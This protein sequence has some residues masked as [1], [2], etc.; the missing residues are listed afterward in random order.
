MADPGVKPE[1]E[2][3]AAASELGQIDVSPIEALARIKTDHEGVEAL[4]QRA[5]ERREGVPDAVYQRVLRDYQAR[6]QELDAQARPLRERARGE[7]RRLRDIHGRLR[8]ALD[9]AVLDRQEIEFRHDISEMTDEEFETR[10]LTA[11]GIVGECQAQ[12]DKA[13][14]LRGRF[15]ELIPEPPEEAAAPPVPAPAP[16][17]ATSKELSEPE[18]E[19]ATM[20][21]PV[22]STEAPEGG[23]ASSP[24]LTLAVPIGRLVSQGANGL[25]YVLGSVTTIGRTSDNDIAV[26]VKAVSRR[27][28]RVEV[29][30]EGYLLKDLGSGN[31]TFVNDKRI[32]ERVLVEGDRVRLG[33]EDF[34]FRFGE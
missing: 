18:F 24:M 23:A 32:D 12:F 1:Q 3:A 28:A 27:H 20:A 11:D 7:F 8:R 16:P 29:T 4:I 13:D 6:L 22:P 30:A 26:N 10:H 25:S 5:N 19:G 31:G 2:T 33:T 14:A 21:T 17:P 9:A 15:L 34:V